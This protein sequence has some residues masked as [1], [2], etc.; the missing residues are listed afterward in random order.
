MDPADPHSPIPR[1]MINTAVSVA[2]LN[3]NS[4][5]LVR[6]RSRL[7]LSLS[8][9]T[10]LL[11][12]AWAGVSF[13]DGEGDKPFAEAL[14]SVNARCPSTIGELVVPIPDESQFDQMS[15]PQILELLGSDSPPMRSAA[16]NAMAR[17][18]DEVIP[19]LEKSLQN[20]NKY[21][22]AGAATAL[23]R[24]IQQQTRD[25]RTANP[26]MTAPQAQDKARQ[27]YLAQ[28]QLFVPLTKS[29]DREV[30]DA[31]LNALLSVRPDTLAVKEAILTLCADPDEYIAERA[32]NGFN[33]WFKDS[34]VPR[35]KVLQGIRSALQ[36]PLPGGKGSAVGV[37]KS[38]DEKTQR[39]FIPVLL[40]HLDWQPDRD[41]MFGAAGQAEALGMLTQ[42]H[43][44]EVVPRI[45]KLM[46]KTMRGPGLFEP[47]IESVRAFGKDSA[48]IVPQ[49]IAYADELEKNLPSAP[50]R[51]KP[52]IQ[53][54]I[55]SLRE[56]V[57]YVQGL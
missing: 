31:S 9:A 56:T 28:G 41:T 46:K 40:A 36:Q 1:K 27:K 29:P 3:H 8:T 4:K 20:G 37:I 14:K 53:I 5:S 38:L 55:D 18:G 33:K 17:R 12:L 6:S 24:L 42:L 44:T 50:A 57:K 23:S 2:E 11:P 15:V 43:V 52:G 48:V 13:A 34:D 25:L 47:C 32:I 35:D 10:M 30:R 21:M 19:S 49:L 51:N 7:R 45:P 16:A 39:E 22:I 54:K 26:G